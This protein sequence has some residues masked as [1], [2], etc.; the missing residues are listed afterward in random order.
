MT[1]FRFTHMSDLHLTN[2]SGVHWTKLLNKRLSGYLFWRYKRQFKHCPKVLAAVAR[3]AKQDGEHLVLTGD[4]T[5]TSLP[6]ECRQAASWLADLGAGEDISVIPGNHDA[7]VQADWSANFDLWRP[8]M[9]SDANNQSVGHLFP[10]VRRRGPI[11]FIGLSSAVPTTLF[12]ANGRVDAGQLMRLKQ[13]L[14]DNRDFFRVVLIHH[15]PA[16]EGVSWRRGLDNHKAVRKVFSD[17]GVELVLHGH[18]HWPRW[19]QLTTSGGL[20]PVIGIPAASAVGLSHNGG[21][22]PARA[23]YYA[24]EVSRNKKTWQLNVMAY[25][26]DLSGEAMESIGGRCYESVP[27]FLTSR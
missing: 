9:Q 12:F 21:L 8:W 3:H 16:S 6:E 1:L 5:Q 22:A 18:D 27:A 13:I 20:I 2:P 14:A 23:G 15:S 4:L 19:H 25:R 7:Y 17:E 11:A 24:Y 26:L 10:F